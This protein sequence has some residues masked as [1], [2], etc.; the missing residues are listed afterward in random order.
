DLVYLDGFDL[1]PCPLEE[2]IAILAVRGSCLICTEDRERR[3]SIMDSGVAAVIGA[4]IGGAAS[5]AVQALSEFIRALRQKRAEAPR[6]TMLMRLLENPAHQW[7]DIE[8]L[9]RVAGLSKEEARRLCIE[10]GARA[11]RDH[12]QR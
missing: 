9:S 5:L 7:R 1:R 6:R 2:R 3:R 11:G 12:N 10:I 8:T 4:A